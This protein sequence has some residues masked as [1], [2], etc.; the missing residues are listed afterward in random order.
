MLAGGY[1]FLCFP[2][3]EAL[4]AECVL[5]P[6]ESFPALA[7]LSRPPEASPDMP[8]SLVAAAAVTLPLPVVVKR[9]RPEP[10]VALF[11]PESAVIVPPLPPL[12]TSAVKP[13]SPVSV[14]DPMLA[15]VAGAFPSL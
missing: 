3:P 5:L 12:S 4:T 13:M 14:L 11:R 15:P 9:C 8:L 10:A 7:V 2:P 6:P 1:P